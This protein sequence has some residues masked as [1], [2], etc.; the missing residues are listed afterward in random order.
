MGQVV[1]PWSAAALAQRVG[2]TLAGPDRRF[3]GLATIEDAGPDEL[4]YLERGEGG[5]AGVLL[6]RA[7]IEGRSVVVVA[8]PKAAFIVVLEAF[9]PAE[10]G[11]MRHASA[12]IDPSARVDPSARIHPGVVI[13]A[14]CEVGE[15]SELFPHVVL[16]PGT[17]VGKRARIHAGAVVG[18]DG[19]SYHPTAGGLLKV[20]QVG[21]V[22]IEDEV[23]VGAGCTIDR[24]FL[25]ET[26]IGRGSK[27]DNLVHVGHN[28]QIG[29]G[30]VIAAQTGISG[31]VT[32]GDFVQIGGQVGIA[33]HASVGDRVRIGAQSGVHGRLAEGEAYLGTP[34]MPL[35]LTRRVYATLRHLPEMW[36]RT[37]HS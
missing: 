32:I 18:A 36:R 17:R 19:F 35:A 5:A 14:D 25:G 16:Y 21:R 24:A 2:G 11:P 31:S 22:V 34:A 13:G 26:R 20:P 33:D 28:C 37:R 30:V 8:D 9:H 6:A 7:P 1:E 15:G 27:L 4:A 10:I 23:E 29:R 3:T 12:V